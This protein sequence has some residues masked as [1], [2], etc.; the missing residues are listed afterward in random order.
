MGNWSG[1]TLHYLSVCLVIAPPFVSRVRG[2]SS[3]LET[4]GEWNCRK[5]MNLLEREAKLI[6][7]R[8]NIHF[9]CIPSSV[10]FVK[11]N[12]FLP[13][14]R[15]LLSLLYIYTWVFK[16]FVEFMKQ[17]TPQ[18]ISPEGNEWGCSWIRK[19]HWQVLLWEPVEHHHEHQQHQMKKMRTE[20][21]REESEEES[22]GRQ[23]N[24]DH[25]LHNL[26]FFSFII[27]IF[28]FSRPVIIIIR[29]IIILAALF[30]HSLAFK[31]RSLP[32]P[33]FISF[34][35]SDSHSK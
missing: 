14:S 2:A 1:H 22:H 28:L 15:L 3:S 32:S 26:F 30:R 24:R 33:S 10:V 31:S 11:E 4:E 9:C 6:F 18:E 19:C 7:S 5:R 34:S 21:Q 13:P 8:K 35:S 25:R 23:L 17:E 29:V 12:K 20:I 27:G 16:K